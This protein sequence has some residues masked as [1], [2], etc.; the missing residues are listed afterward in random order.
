MPCVPLSNAPETNTGAR[1]WRTMRD[2]YPASRP[3]PGEFA[4][5]EAERLNELGYGDAAHYELLESRV[6]RV[7]EDQVRIEHHL[8]DLGTGAVITVPPFTNYQQ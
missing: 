3:T 7:G 8:R 5:R 6:S 1:S 2:A 4:R